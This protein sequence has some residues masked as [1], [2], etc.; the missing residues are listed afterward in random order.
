M[1]TSSNTGDYYEAVIQ[2]RPDSEQIL[3]FI[4]NSIKKRGNVFIAK[5][6]KHKTGVDIY[7]SD[8]HFAQAL[9]KKM[10]KSFK[11]SLKVSR[12]LYGFHRVSS[13]IVYRVTILFRVNP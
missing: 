13:K 10:K 2:L 5:E 9:G 12:T 11:G 7:L 8:Q 1:P 3:R 4:H 6:V